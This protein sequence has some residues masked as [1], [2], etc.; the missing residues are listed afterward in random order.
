MARIRRLAAVVGVAALAGSFVGGPARADSAEVFQGKATGTALDLAILGNE[1][2]LGSS[3]AEADSAGN[4][5]AKGAGVLLPGVVGSTEKVATAS[6][7]STDDQPRSCAETLSIEGSDALNIGL[8]CS[9]AKAVSGPAP[10]ATGQG[11]VVDAGVDATAVINKLIEVAE[12]VEDASGGEVDLSAA[13]DGISQLGGT[14][15]G[16]VEPVCEAAEAAGAQAEEVV[17][18]ATTTVQDLVTSVLK[19]KTLEVGV[20]T[21]TS[22]VDTTDASVTS[23]AAASGAVVKLLPLPQVNG[24]PS[25]EPVVTITVGKAKASATYDRG[26]GVATGEADPA[27]VHIKFNTVL[28]DMLADK[29]DSDLP[30]GLS[31]KNIVLTPQSLLDIEEQ[32]GSG[33]TG[34]IEPCEDGRAVCI[35]PGSPL[36]SKI[37]LA[38]S[39]VTTNDDGTV[40]A[41][42]DAVRMELATGQEFEELLDT[43]NE[44]G[45]LA[46][47]DLEGPGVRLALA[48]VEAGVGGRP[49]QDDEDPTPTTQPPDEL[50]RTSDDDGDPERSRTLPPAELPRTGGTPWVPLVGATALALAVIARRAAARAIR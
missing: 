29:L 25:T 16:L 49:A 36:E 42:A 38:S 33:V 1:V 30:A 32:L 37:W 43:V 21:T 8:A 4:A 17:C 7:G 35:L 15:A 26:K 41:T 22:S 3:S 18:S 19:T 9:S 10:S 13:K 20:G 11:S 31:L 2:T 28:T 39:K 14:V 34:V 45:S 27:I 47:L 12:T 46:E 24:L 40:V 50:D 6:N 44:A 48:S 5:E 23:Q